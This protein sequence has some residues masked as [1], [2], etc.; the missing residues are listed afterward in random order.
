MN[1]SI[2][3]RR[4]LVSGFLTKNKTETEIAEICQ[5]SRQ[6]IVRDVAAIKSQ[7]QTWLDGLAKNGFVFEFK[8]TLDKIKENGTRLESLLLEAKDIWQKLAILKAIEQNA[9]LY[10]ELI[11]ETPTIHAY[12]KATKVLTSV[13]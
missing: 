2:K 7:S 8:K 11:G 5:V 12:R 6:T 3:K 10:L 9:K 13:S 4:E 1:D